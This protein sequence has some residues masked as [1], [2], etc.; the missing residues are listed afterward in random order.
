MRMRIFFS[1][2]LLMGFIVNAY[3]ADNIQPYGNLYL[4]SGLMYEESY[5][6][7]EKK[8]KNSDLIHHI[9]ENSNLG[10]AF[11]Y[12]KFK[13]VF[14][15]GLEG[16]ENERSVKVR[17]AYGEYNIGFGT[18]MIGQDWSPYVSFSNEMADYYRS[19]GFGSLYEDPKLQISLSFYNFYLT[20]EKPYV[21][22]TRFITNQQGTTPTSEPSSTDYIPVTVYKEKTTG[23]TLDYVDSY[24]PKFAVGYEY[25]NKIFQIKGGGAGN[26]YLIKDTDTVR[27]SQGYIY[28][29]LFYLNSSYKISDFTLSF[30]GGY[31]VNPA[32]FG[33]FV[34]S[35]GNTTYT[36]GAAV[37]LK[38]DATKKWE[39]KDTWNVQ[40]FVELEY[41]ITDSMIFNAGYGYSLVDYPIPGSTKDM[42]M[43]YYLNCKYVF[44]GL[45]ALTPS[46]SLRDYMKDMSG[47]KEGRELIAGLLATV[48]FY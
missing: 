31:S 23:L 25:N 44:G 37:A 42:A 47:N 13:G 11:H 24:I 5:E 33:I 22:A 12:S 10:F 3:S 6:I 1:I 20:L 32:N 16:E 38:N 34:Q 39:I 46:V 36:G 29:Y 48:S 2:V 18:L 17:K 9:D 28:S 19:K 40:G 26:A 45:I 15:L 7:G 8:V 41:R 43:D 21:P 14:E 35:L 27:F 4:F 30:S